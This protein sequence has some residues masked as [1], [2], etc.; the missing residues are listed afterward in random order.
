M[1]S[2]RSDIFTAS[3]ISVREAG[4]AKPLFAALLACSLLAPAAAQQ[5]TADHHEFEAALEA[6][7]LGGEAGARPLHLRFRYPGAASGQRLRW[8]LDLLDQRGRSLRRWQGQAA[9]RGGALQLDPAWQA[10]R[11]SDAAAARPP[12]G[13]YHLRLRATPEPR[14]R[15]A[16]GKAISQ[17]SQAWRA[18]QTIEQSWPI[19]IGPPP[20]LRIVASKALPLAGQT[21]AAPPAAGS[22]ASSLAELPSAE[23]PYTVYLGNLHSQTGHS[24][25]GGELP[26]CHGA[27]EPQSAVAGPAQAFAYA[28][29]HG[30]DFLMTSEHNHMYDGSE[31][32]DPNA[33]ASSARQLYQ[34]GLEQTAAFNAAHP[35]FLG[36]YGMEWGVISKG[37]HLNIFNSPELLG[38]ERNGAGEL[39]GDTFTAKGDYASLYRLMRERGWIGQFNHPGDSQFRIGGQAFAFSSDGEQ[40]MV[41]C[42]VMN[43][44]AFSSRSDEQESH[45]SNY[46]ERCRTLLEAGYHLAFSSNQ[47]NHC[48]NWG[49]SYSNRTGVL[50][51]AGDTLTLDNLVAALRQR[52]VFA[53]M[54]KGSQLIFSANGHLMGERFDNS[55]PLQFQLSYASNGGRS[56]VLVEI[57]EGVPGQKASTRLLAQDR[58]ALT[59]TPALGEH[60]YYV[61]L[62][63]DDG[64]QLWSA[65]IWVSQQA[66]P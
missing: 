29:E 57:F 62:T 26:G 35:G 19:A 63:Q 16:R 31:G 22:A 24:D 49:A 52:R 25:G 45:L 48:A 1:V 56:P 58:D 6:P 9:L 30:L 34:S 66:P 54:D 17:A 61:R 47:D 7:F 37:G 14:V 53:T 39:M 42:E 28:R 11:A 55:G 27:Q 43:S 60:F 50:L 13:L 46:E 3:I 64:K 41:L 10:G 59:I 12:A 36:I 44:S 2:L 38:W 5:G 32:S 51:P 4:A 8:Q 40:A 18:E 65:P 33:D 20:A 21:A 15:A 23:R